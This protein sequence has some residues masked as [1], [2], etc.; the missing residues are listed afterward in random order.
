[1]YDRQEN[2]ENESLWSQV[3]GQAIVGE[4]AGDTLTIYTSTITNFGI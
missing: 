4:R 1:M 2:E 3:L